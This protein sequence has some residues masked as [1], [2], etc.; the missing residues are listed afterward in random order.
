MATSGKCSG[1]REL[2]PVQ[3][4]VDYVNDVKPY[5]TKII[6]VLVEYVHEDKINVTIL[7]DTDWNI[8]LSWPSEEM[9]ELT[10][11]GGY[12]TGLFGDPNIWPVVSPNPTI[13]FEAYPAINTFT[14]TFTLIGDRTG[15]II[16]GMQ[17]ELITFVENFEFL[18]PIVEAN[19]GP[20]GDP[21]TYFVVE[22]PFGDFVLAHP[23]YVGS[24]IDPAFHFVETLGTSNDNRPFTVTNVSP[25]GPG[26]TK[27]EVGQ[28]ILPQLT[29]GSLG[30]VRTAGNNTGTYTVAQVVYNGGSIDSWP[31]YPNPTTYQIG[32]DPHTIVSVVEPLNV[33]SFTP[34]VGSPAMLAESYSAFVRLNSAIVEKVLSYSNFTTSYSSSPLSYSQTPDEGIL[35]ESVVAVT[36]SSFAVEGNLEIS[37][38]FVGDTLRILSSSGNNGTYIIADIS[39]DVGTNTT[40]ISV[41]EIV[42]SN[43]A[44][45]ILEIDIPANVF[46]V[47]GDFRSRFTQG[48]EFSVSGG[49]FAG[50]YT[51][52][53]SDYVNGKTRIR[54]TRDII[55]TRVGYDIVEVTTGI[56]INNDRTD[57]FSAGTQVNVYGSD[58]NDGSYVVASSS[59]DS[60]SNTT[61]IVPDLGSPVDVHF[62]P[63]GA[64]G[65]IRAVTMGVIKSGFNTLGFAEEPDFCEFNPENVVRVKFEERL[66]FEGAGLDLHDDIIAY[67]LENNDQWGYELPV[68]T[69]VDSTAP[70][71]TEGVAAPVSPD[72]NDLWYNCTGSPCSNGVL[73]R[74]NGYKW[75]QIKTAWWLDSTTNLLYY[76]TRDSLV[77]TGWVLYLAEPPGFSDVQ[78]ANATLNTNAFVETYDIQ[79]HQVYHRG[80]TVYP[81][82]PQQNA[83]VL[84]G[85][86]YVN[87]FIAENQFDV[88]KT[89]APSSHLTTQCAEQ[90]NIIDVDDVAGTITIEGE[91]DW[92][93]ELGRVFSIRTSEN[94]FNDF[95]V[96]SSISYGSPVVTTITVAFPD[97]YQTPVFYN[98]GVVVTNVDPVTDSITVMGNVGDAYPVGSNIMLSAS[99]TG[100]NGTWEVA[101]V[102]YFPPVGSPLSEP[103]TVIYV[104]GNLPDQDSSGNARVHT[105][106]FQNYSRDFGVVLGAVYDPI[107]DTTNSNDQVKTFVV[108]VD[109][110]ELDVDG[111]TYL[112]A[113]PLRVELAMAYQDSSSVTVVGQQSISGVFDYYQLLIKESKPLR[114]SPATPVMVFEV[115]GDATPHVLFGWSFLVSGTQNNDG[116]YVVAAPPTYNPTTGTTDIPVSNIPN[117]EV[118]GWVGPIPGSS[119]TPITA[120][121]TIIEN[122]SF[123]WGVVDWFQYLIREAKPERGSPAVPVMVFEVYGNATNDLQIG[124]QFRVMGTT[125]DGVYTVTS[126]LTYNAV[127]NTT[128]IPVASIANNERGGWVESYEDY[129]IRLI[130]EDNI[131]VQVSENAESTILL[132]SG[133]LLGAWDYPHYDIGSWDETLGTVIYLYSN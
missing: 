108:P 107:V 93:F 44:D 55:D 83:Y 39:Y 100:N 36:P 81:G 68:G 21:G 7:E 66:V 22:D 125:N 17:I 116:T 122:L 15:D 12:A 46:V 52:L 27:V 92:L 1:F 103:E 75:K 20:A 14:N 98:P 110:V 35:R 30:L 119:D 104:T 25:Y 28:A 4:L 26:L 13:P 41:E 118:G 62:I 74:W 8:G 105:P 60:I 59:Y 10:C 82:S 49:S 58:A 124:Q 90:F 88:W 80:V 42:T 112:W 9:A 99:T 56:V 23:P 89:S 114:G 51:V 115:Y 61:T 101:S 37:N 87:R 128:D 50:T 5:H 85:G 123:G 129:G 120:D 19:A 31:G 78:P 72:I 121:A 91:W 3:G 94:N 67:N 111:I 69:R 86:N 43:V 40:V 64:G 126:A 57:V 113:G 76:R 34:T 53:T 84:Y 71:I 79:A 106:I 130:F 45:G 11:P 29:G 6:E 70:I 63:S 38:I 77:D 96:E 117:T 95:V 24:P 16:P 48:K 97:V 54:T 18:Y 132:S 102:S 133:S 33:P 65:K 47:S 73:H 131:G 127:T 32:N 109:P 2:D